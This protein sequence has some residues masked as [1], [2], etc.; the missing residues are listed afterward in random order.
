MNNADDFLGDK[1]PR[2]I[3]GNAGGVLNNPDGIQSD[4][5]HHLARST[6]THDKRIAGRTGGDQGCLEPT[7]K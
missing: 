6:G 5:T 1:G 7:S 3:P 2:A 4:S